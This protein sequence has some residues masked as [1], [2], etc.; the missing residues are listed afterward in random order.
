[1]VST[2]SQPPAINV[3]KVVLWLIL[4]LC[5]I[6]GLRDYVLSPQ[7]QIDVLKLFAFVPGRFTYAYDPQRLF[8]A[9]QQL[10]WSHELG[11][12]N[13]A[14]VFLGDGHPQ[15]WTPLTYAGLHGDWVHLGVN[16]LWLLAF[17]SPVVDLFT[18]VLTAAMVSYV[19]A[20]APVFA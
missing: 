4:L 9:I 14:R 18:H 11:Q 12:I 5:A 17:G 16:S 2:S 20:A 6:Q 3:P 7:Q 19:T 15:W 8:D 10:E 13:A 1:M